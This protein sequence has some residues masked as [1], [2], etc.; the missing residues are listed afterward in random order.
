[1]KAVI[2]AGGRGT[3]FWPL[4]R[5][6]RPKQF[7]R[8]TGD[9][10]LLQETVSRLEPIVPQDEVFIACGRQDLEAVKEQLPGLTSDQLIVEP[11]GRNTAPAIGLAAL[12]LQA[13][14]G[15]EVMA[16]LPAD[17]LISNQEEFHKVLH[18]AE[19]LA[20]QGWLT[21]FAIHPTFPSTGYGYLER[22]DRLDS[23]H[24]S[25][26]FAVRK[27]VEKPDPEG[28]RRFLES[29]RHFWNSGMFVWS[30][31]TIRSAIQAHQPEIHALLER[32]SRNGSS[33]E[34]IETL[35]PEM[36]SISI[37]Y[38]VMEKA[39]RVAGIPCG[40]G[41]SDVGG[42]QALAELLPKDDRGI[43]ARGQYIEVESRDSLVFSGKGKVTA[44]VGV[45]DLVIV[46]T[47]D[48]LLVCHRDRS[49]DVKEVVKRLKAEGRD[50]WL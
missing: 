17:H 38:G 9:K 37:D 35:F 2:M 25:R 41:W 34:S 21:A 39:Q 7:L 14:F 47:E 16:V 5:R 40:L 3:R 43:S 13:L 26:P 36:P 44:L 30:T 33:P 29:G 49:E 46:D 23:D 45:R 12:H 28:A 6:E 1:M 15:E 50:P 8:L 4:S 20:R 18:R 48:A 22:G 10:T 19:G 11:V 31:E 27:F 42:W 32:I 24:E